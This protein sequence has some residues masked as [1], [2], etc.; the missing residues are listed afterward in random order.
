MPGVC[1]QTTEGQKRASGPLELFF[2]FS[3]ISAKARGIALVCSLL[4]AWL[5][6]VA[7]RVL[8]ANVPRTHL[9]LRASVGDGD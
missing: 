1:T 5:T 2:M 6:V 8:G 3:N 4:R 9:N 7:T